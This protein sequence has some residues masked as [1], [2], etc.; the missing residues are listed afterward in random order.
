M[1]LTVE[2]T[3]EGEYIKL[4]LFSFVKFSFMTVLSVNFSQSST[5]NSLKYN[6]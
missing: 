2:H 3:L 1:D 5:D 4:N 6:F